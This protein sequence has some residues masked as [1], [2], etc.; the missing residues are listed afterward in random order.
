MFDVRGSVFIGCLS[1]IVIFVWLD[2]KWLEKKQYLLS[3]G[4]D[5]CKIVIKT[6]T[7]LV[8]FFEPGSL[9][10]VPI[11]FADKRT[12]SRKQRLFI[13]GSTF[14]GPWLK[15]KYALVLSYSTKTTNFQAMKT[16]G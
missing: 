15:G 11:I 9:E 16:M 4:G 12:F 5:L 7:L 10:L 13:P 1:Y 14:E 3:H 2:I 6:F 8:K